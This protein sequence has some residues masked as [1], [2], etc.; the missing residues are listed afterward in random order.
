MPLPPL[1]EELALLP[2]A[3]LADGQ[4]S[5][6]LHDPVRNLFFQIDWP[7]FEVLRRWHLD[8]IASI[9]A[10][11]SAETT[12][13]L[14]AAD[15]EEVIKFFADNQLL[16]P[17]P[18]SAADFA[19]RLQTRRGSVAQRL[20]HN[21]LFFRVP[22]VKPDR[23]LGRW[24]SHLDVFYS[25]QFL[26]LTLAVLAWGLVEVYRQWEHFA[27][28]LVDT[29]SWSGLAS[30][31][32]TLAAVKTLHELGHAF[33]AKRL[34]CKVPTMGVAFLVLWP[35][36][37][38]DTNEVW[39]LTERRQRLAVVAA[40][41]LT[42]LTIAAWATLAWTLLPEGTP[43]ALAFMLATTTWIA[44]VA[45]NASPFMRFDGYF[46]LSD[47]LGMPNLHARAFA[48]ARWDMRERLFALGAP[49]PENFP[50]RRHVGLILFAYA[51]WIYRL[52]VFL[53]IA[54]LVYAFFIKAVGILLFAVEI[55]WFVAL[56][57]YREFQSWYAMRSVLRDLPRARRSAAIALA[58]ALL[59]I[60]PWPTRPTASGLLR[61]TAQFVVYA[62]PHAQVA[63]VPIAEGQHVDAGT[64]LLMLTSPDIATRLGSAEARRE[65]L[66][67]Q[68]SAGA[69]D[70]EQRAQWQVSL[71]QLSAAEAEVAAIQ[72]DAARYE[73]A[74]PFAGVLRDLHPDLR[75]GTW[76]SAQE[77]LARLIADQGETAI[78][79]L[80]EE[81]VGRI[82]LG[83][84]ARFYADTP[85]GPVV[86]L[87][88]VSID[89][90][91]SHVLPEPE[92]ATLFG[93]GVVVREKNG[94]FYP[95]RPV[96]RITLKAV[97]SDP[98]AT[99]HTWRGKVVISG[100]WVAPGWRYVRSALALV[101]REA[102][103]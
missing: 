4:P 28:T 57:F 71:E 98:T 2:G 56:P 38:T 59:L 101:R 76:V 65:R 60:L 95:D 93:G 78:A 88:V 31:G 79:Y 35:V 92:L 47:W 73:P 86:A 85:G 74:A 21:Y 17:R 30:Y 19:T 75:P 33:T 89:A 26:Y 77:P 87:K 46:L 70:N 44:T 22:L 50:R 54:G 43:K 63:D 32:I 41:V 34:G 52:V 14:H 6:T 51:T 7:T 20:L 39:K 13:Q 67:W 15:V 97:A 58:L 29:L 16:K 27:A 18:G 96:F 9:A 11:I 81:D 68:A 25:R 102:G 48:L 61:P 55:G 100:N 8:D 66:R 90:D 94:Q 23:W 72:A 83:D 10:A 5:H 49:V 42:E 36:A 40:G 1:R 84:S 62:P 53:G 64:V 24:A 45:I 12:L 82:A 69:F 99:Q 3:V 91:A 37:Y 103:F 80:D